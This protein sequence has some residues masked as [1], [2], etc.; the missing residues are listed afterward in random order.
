VL[1]GILKWPLI[2]AAVVVVLRVVVERAGAPGVVSNMLSV[3][4][5][6]TLLGPLYFAVRIGSTSQPRPYLMLI[7]LI[8]IY[9]ILT[10]AMILPTYW[11]ARI[12][13]WPEPR[14]Y[15]LFGPDV[16]PYAGFIEL[17]FLTAG[18]WIV[19][20]VVIGGALGAITLAIVRSRM[21]T[22]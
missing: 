18:F 14:F 21:K 19:A 5:L 22:A 8:A 2:V 6:H 20:S 4:A 17:P 1:R 12:F 13:E 3:A 7:K 15:G 16:T 10:R 9:A 11:L